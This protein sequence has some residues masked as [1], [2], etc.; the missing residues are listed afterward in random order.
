[1][2]DPRRFDGLLTRFIAGDPVARREL[3]PLLHP[4]LVRRARRAAA[5]SG[6]TWLGDD[7]VARA[8]EILVTGRVSFDPVR[9]SGMTFVRLTM[10]NA[11]R[12]VRAQHVAPGRRTRGGDVDADRDRLVAALRPLVQIEEADQVVDRVVVREALD[13][14][15]REVWPAVTVLMGGGSM[16]A[17]A[18]AVGMQRSTLIRMLRRWASAEHLV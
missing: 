8:W 14:L 3:P 17:A 4:L 16:S 10:L 13:A 15:D 12:D 9:A 7:V 5:L 6:V 1:M 2:H 18:E 11:L